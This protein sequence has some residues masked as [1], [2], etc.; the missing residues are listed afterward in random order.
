MNLALESPHQ[1]LHHQTGLGRECVMV[2]LTSNSVTPYAT[3]ELAHTDPEGRRY[4][5]RGEYVQTETQAIRSLG[6][7]T[8]KNLEVA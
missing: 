3:Y 8:G 1:L 7:R 2:R 6:Y 4:C 5:V